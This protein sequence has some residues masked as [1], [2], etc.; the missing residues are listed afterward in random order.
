MTKCG[1][2][3]A[4]HLK[5]M[6]QF[7]DGT[8]PDLET[9]RAAIASG[10]PVQAMPALTQLRFFSDEEAVPLLVLGTQQQ[11]FLVRSLSCSGLGVK[12]N[13]EGWQV[14]V[15]LLRSDGD[16]NVRGQAANAA[17][18]DTDE[19]RRHHDRRGRHLAVVVVE[20]REMLGLEELGGEETHT[21][22]IFRAPALLPPSLCKRVWSIS[23]SIIIRE[24]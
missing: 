14:L 6:T 3:D 4:S 20:A 12:R 19:K 5:R 9:L 15:R 10:D 16:A 7:S 2:K 23:I 13:E 11:P 24:P 21:R 22:R 17:L 18:A 8:S 1:V